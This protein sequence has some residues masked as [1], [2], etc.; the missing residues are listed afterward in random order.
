MFFYSESESKRFNL[1]VHRASGDASAD[2][3]NKYLVENAVDLLILRTPVERKDLAHDLFQLGFPT[4][5][6]DNL[7]TYTAELQKIEI[8]P[9]KNDIVFEEVNAQNVHEIRE[10]I[11]TIFA[12]YQNHYSS[13]HFIKRQD[14][15]DG[16]IEWASSS[17][18]KTEGNVGWIAKVKGVKVGFA[19]CS[20]NKKTLSSEG[21]LYGILPEHGKSGFYTDLFRH[22]MRYFKESQFHTFT[23]PTQIQNFA[24]QKVWMRE[25]LKLTSASDTYHIN[26]FLKSGTKLNTNANSV[27]DFEAIIADYVTKNFPGCSIQN[28]S[29]VSLNSQFSSKNLEVSHR[30]LIQNPTTNSQLLI[31]QFFNENKASAIFYHTLVI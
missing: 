25:G 23:I 18:N 29:M 9:S 5:H 27:N 28:S 30:L 24:V 26:A 15:L 3:L 11:P 1:N 6:A 19:T 10:M 16:Y 22:S 20:Y 12:D 7:V 21:V 17:L 2:T 14:I 13:N 8:G 31:T 4:L